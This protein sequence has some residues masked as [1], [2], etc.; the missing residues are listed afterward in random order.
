MTHSVPKST[1][2]AKATSAQ[3]PKPAAGQLIQHQQPKSKFKIVV[4]AKKPDKEPQAE[5][6]AQ[7][8]TASVV[9][10]PAAASTFS[11]AAERHLKW[12]H[13]SGPAVRGGGLTDLW[14]SHKDWMD[15]TAAHGWR[16]YTE[17][18]D[19]DRQYIWRFSATPYDEKISIGAD[20][21]ISEI[22][23]I[24]GAHSSGN[25]KKS[26]HVRTSSFCRNIGALIGT[27][28]SA[29]G[30]KN[31]LNIINKAPYLLCIDVATLRD[32]GVSAMPALD[33][34]ISLYETE[35]VLVA[36][37]GEEHFLAC[38]PVDLD[39]VLFRNPFK[40][41]IDSTGKF[42]GCTVLDGTLI[43][44][45][46]PLTIRATESFVKTVVD[47]PLVFEDIVTDFAE[48][49]PADLENILWFAAASADAASEQSGSVQTK[50]ALG[51]L[52]KAA[53]M[54]KTYNDDIYKLYKKS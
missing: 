10:Q 4:R 1:D 19:A 25:E 47:S 41:C 38:H 14:R 7:P 18:D 28:A 46:V 42:M 17:F 49:P 5:V 22:I 52:A 27:A 3:P 15:Y 32:K 6:P 29:G 54:M 23:K 48:I 39:P 30:D 34:G 24:I 21:A 9:Q 53:N 50:D 44:A 33:R 13:D 26:A 8:P 40:G 16:H 2:D 20:T 12:L 51:G 11:P 36:T 31:V 35:Y 45:D 43:G 37:P